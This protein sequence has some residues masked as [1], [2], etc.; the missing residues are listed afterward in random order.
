MMG[1]PGVARAYY[2]S[3]RVAAERRIRTEADCAICHGL[4]GSA[5]AGLG[6]DSAAVREGLKAVELRPAAKDAWE[7][8]D[9]VFGLARI[10]AAIGDY[11]AALEQVAM[12]L[13]VPSRYSPEWFSV[14]PAW[15]ELRQHPRFQQVLRSGS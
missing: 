11:D 2:D 7:G 3:L 10:Y 1:R 14:H 5:Y 12:L 4:L 8:P 15:K 6:L 9:H 13:R